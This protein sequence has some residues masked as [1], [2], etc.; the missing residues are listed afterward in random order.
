MN[1]ISLLEEENFSASEEVLSDSNGGNMSKE[2]E[3]EA[4]GKEV[5][6]KASKV[7]PQAAADSKSPT[8]KGGGQRDKKVSAKKASE[9]KVGPVAPEPAKAKKTVPAKKAAVEKKPEEVKSATSIK[10]SPV[11]KQATTAAKKITSTPAKKTQAARPA[12]KVDVPEIDAAPTSYQQ[13]EQQANTTAL[14]EIQETSVDITPKTSKLRKITFQIKFQ[15]VIGQSLFV[16]GSHP[17]FGSNDP[18][19]AF[20][21]SY[22]N[23]NYW[24]GTMEVSDEAPLT[25]DISYNY[26]LKN[27]DGSTTAEWGT[28]KVIQYGAFDNE[29]LLLIDSWNPSSLVANTYYT[30]PFQEVLLKENFTEIEA[31]IPEK[32]T[33]VFRAKAP[34]LARGQAL[35]IIGSI[36]ELGHWSI[37]QPLLLSRKQGQMWHSISLDLSDADFPFNYKYGVYDTNTNT[38]LEYES[39]NNR[40]LYDGASD[41]LTVVSDGFAA[42]SNNGFKGAGVAIPVFSLRSANSCGVGEFADLKLMVDWAKKVGLKLIQLLPVNDTT[43][44]HTFTDSYPYAAISAFALHPLYLHLPAIVNKENQHL[45]TDLQDRQTEL[46]SKAEVDYVEVMRVKW[47]LIKQIFPSQKELTFRSPDFNAFFAENEHWLVPYAAFS[48]FREQ[49]KTADFNQWES[50]QKFDAQQIKELAGS[51]LQADEQISV[52]YYIQYH[53]HLQL[54]DA[55]NYAHQNGIIVKGDIPIGIYRNSCDAWQEPDLFYM[56]MQAGAPPDDFAVKGQNWGFPTYNWKRMREDGFSW[57]KKRF[58]Q[59]SYYFDAF[60]ID[61]ILGFFRIWS[62][63]MNAV[64]GIM[65]HFVPAMP[66]HINELIGRGIPFNY[67]R[68]CTPFVN[69]TV[70]TR[71][72]AGNLHNVTTQFLDALSDGHYK[73]KPEFDTQRKV[74]AHFASQEDTEQ[75]LNIKQGLFNLISNV[76]FF[77]AEGS[78][79]QQFHFRIAMADTL[80]Y[81][82]LDGHSKHHLYE[83]YVNYFF[84][85]QDN[86]WEKEAM[87]KLPELKRSTNMLICGEDLGMVPDCVPGVMKELAILSLEIQRMPKD[88]TREFFHP[89]DAPYLS[90]VTPSTHDM[91]TIRG[92]WEEDRA[93]TQRFFNSQLG[94]WGT[95][96]YFCEPWINRIILLQHLYSP[97]MW[98]IFQLQDLLG[99]SATLRRENPNEERINIPANPKHYWR[100]RMH[101]PLEQLVNEDEFISELKLHVVKSGR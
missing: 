61:H 17:L 71:F 56:D 29:E 7:V 3:Q 34:L 24:F 35:C 94:Q 36:P 68:F 18:E 22:L 74:E 14:N 27:A 48:F 82:L 28:D 38:F 54:N 75:N 30:E 5:K 44:T 50:H 91:S 33:H 6:K 21:L 67:D 69:D 19:K 93:A 53:L 60:R 51:P 80:S 92:W 89:N 77:E 32:V 83:L 87:L 76:I 95:A 4:T 31:I 101:I 66:V 26:I 11:A 84:R 55:T 2:N 86:Y 49:N 43:A 39:G 1:E 40:V 8:Q 96:P 85:R 58:T 73:L 72:F 98:S 90:V 57:W 81:Q 63:P 46:N 15:T 97:A 52:Y 42:I 16:S 47:N 79:Q 23:E 59:M 25:S 13:V 45:L 70:L 64:E 10:K 62:I 88:P 20:P 41:K 65:G 100:Y 9:K 37:E 78:E 99:M 12:I